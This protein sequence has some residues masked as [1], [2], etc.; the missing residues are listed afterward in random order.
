MKALILND[1]SNASHVGC[2]LVM[3]NIQRECRKVGIDIISSIPYNSPNLPDRVQQLADRFD[4]AL[5]NGEGT[6]HHDRMAAM[7]LAD[8]V[9]IIHQ[10]RKKIVLLNTSWYGNKVLNSILPLIDKIYCRESFSL[11]EIKQGGGLA[12]VVP[13]MIFATPVSLEMEPFAQSTLPLIIDSCHT[14]ESKRLAW[15]SI[16]KKGQF[17]AFHPRIIKRIT[18]S[19][20]MSFGFRLSGRSPIHTAD[21]KI[22]MHKIAASKIVFSGR[23]HGVCLAML[24]EKPVIAFSSNTPKIE[25]MYQDIGLDTNHV[26]QLG[27]F[28]LG[29]FSIDE[30]IV[31]FNKQYSKIRSYIQ[32]APQ[33]ISAMFQ[34]IKTLS[35]EI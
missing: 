8:T 25:G 21:P 34:E 4:T 31:Y 24:L 18:R 22:V 16:W 12:K 28:R 19:L 15:I 33:I 10:L 17:L 11:T 20:P 7:K 9:N 32:K 14:K 6:M 3:D 29:R 2:I 35:D 30:H 1:T 27:S 13:D 5:I 23:F 26:Y